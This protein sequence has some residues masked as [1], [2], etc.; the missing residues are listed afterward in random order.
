M[1]GGTWAVIV[2]AGR[3]RRVGAGINKVLLPLLGRPVVAWSL[4][5]FHRVAD[6]DGIVLVGGEADLDQF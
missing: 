5:A 2:A 3:G 6:L 1:T 4:A